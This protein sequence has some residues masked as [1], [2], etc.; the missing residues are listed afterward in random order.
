MIRGFDEEELE[1]AEGQPDTELTLGPGML[2]AI[3]GGL[4][5]LC[6]LCFGLGYWMGHRGSPEASTASQT[7]SGPAQSQVQASSATSKPT[8]GG[9]YKAP[10]SVASE[11]PN[12]ATAPQDSARSDQ[13][14]AVAHDTTA[15]ASTQAQPA[16][17]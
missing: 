5:L 15:Q 6:C 7:A 1:Q 16:P 2:L 13:G 3:G 17:Q 14:A 8:A 10:A 12:D 11:S 9:V 4:L